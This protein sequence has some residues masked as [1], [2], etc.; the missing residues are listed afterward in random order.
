MGKRKA[1]ETPMTKFDK[2]TLFHGFSWHS[3]DPKVLAEGRLAP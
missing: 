1:E 3:G 2:T